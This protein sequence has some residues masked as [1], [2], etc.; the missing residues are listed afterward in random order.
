VHNQLESFL[1][2]SRKK[3][4]KT[5]KKEEVEVVNFK[6]L[7]DK[8]ASFY[9]KVTLEKGCKLQKIFGNLKLLHTSRYIDTIK[10]FG[11]ALSPDTTA[12][13]LAPKAVFKRLFLTKKIEKS[14]VTLAKSSKLVFFRGSASHE[15]LAERKKRSALK[16][17]SLA[18][19]SRIV[20]PKH[21]HHH[22]HTMP[23]DDDDST[24]ASFAL[25]VPY[26]HSTQ[27][28]SVCEEAYNDSA[29]NKRLLLAMCTGL[30]VPGDIALS[31]GGDPIVDFNVT[32]WNSIRKKRRLNLPR[33]ITRQK[34]SAD[35]KCSKN[36]RKRAKEQRKSARNIGMQPNASNG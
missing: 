32:P 23:D 29:Y 9:G 4:Y 27:R 33:R 10:K 15:L 35:S 13:H 19:K 3:T 11:V 26:T 21:S 22:S 2:R 34:C 17:T 8:N 28:P 25:E 14:R 5:L 36:L 6:T 24:Y 1:Q 16:K 12:E 31:A 18:K 30:P 7:C 20:V